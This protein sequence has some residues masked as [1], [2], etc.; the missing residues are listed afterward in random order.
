MVKIDLGNSLLSD[1]DP[2]ETDDDSV[3]DIDYSPSEESSETTS[4]ENLTAID[5][6]DLESD[7][8]DTHSSGETDTWGPIVPREQNLVFKAAQHTNYDK[9]AIKDPIDAYKLFVTDVILDLIVEETN[10][11]AAAC[12]TATSSTRQPKHSTAWKDTN[13]DELQKFFAIIITMGLVPMPKAYW[14][15]DDMYNNR[16]VSGIMPRD[17]FLNILRYLHF[18]NNECA[19]D[20]SI[21]LVKKLRKKKMTYCG[22]LRANSKGIP[23]TFMRKLKRSE[24]Y[25]EESSAKVRVIKW[26]DKRPVMMITSDPSHDANLIDSGKKNSK[27]DAVQKPKC[28][29]DYNK[30]KK[31]VD[32]SDQMSSYFSVLR[33]SLKWYRKVC[34]ELI[35]GT[36]VVNAWVVYND[37]ASSKLSMLNFR[38]KLA[39]ALSKTEKIQEE[40][41]TLKCKLR[42]FIRPEGKG[43]KHRKRCTGCYR[44]LR[45]MF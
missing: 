5:Q 32:I 30:A 45:E 12:L 35:F 38:E 27:G 18:A 34:F 17:R 20:D 25:A 33:K 8:L 31:G 44:K 16:F 10:R 37:A 9:T 11:Y 41:T 28:V 42:T 26:V 43:R 39:R 14:S 7:H 6:K 22:T 36:S 21:P 13:V 40:R 3:A 1:E 24:V 4:D 29:L 19:S 2:F 15:K 23:K